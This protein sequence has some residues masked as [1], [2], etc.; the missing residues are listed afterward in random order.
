MISEKAQ[1]RRTRVYE[2][3]SSQSPPDQDGSI[4]HWCQGGAVFVTFGEDYLK[5]LS[6]DNDALSCVG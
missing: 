1:T 5:A 2:G 3:G 4:P 6:P